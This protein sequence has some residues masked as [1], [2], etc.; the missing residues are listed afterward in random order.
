M[1]AIKDLSTVIQKVLKTSIDNFNTIRLPALETAWGRSFKDEM[2]FESQVTVEIAKNYA[3]PFNNEL[4]RNIQIHLKDFK[5]NTTAGLDFEYIIP[6]EH[7]NSFSADSN[8]WVGN[9][10]KK[11]PMHLLMKF[12]TDENGKINKCFC[13]IIDTSK[14]NNTWSTKGT[15]S[16]FSALKL[17]NDDIQLADIIWGSLV[18]SKKYAKV[19]LN[20]I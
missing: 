14:M 13:C 3:R 10:Y 19:I 9:G 2:K 16:N 1:N 17:S 8:G 7:K 15:T 4:Y 18:P 20:S 6:F 11:T 5:E 12:S